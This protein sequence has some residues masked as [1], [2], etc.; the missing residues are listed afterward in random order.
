MKFEFYQEMTSAVTIA[1]NAGDTAASFIG[2]GGA[3]GTKANVDGNKG[4]VLVGGILK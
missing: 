2:C 4:E 3:V 1:G